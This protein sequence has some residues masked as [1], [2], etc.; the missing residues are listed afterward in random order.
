MFNCNNNDS[1]LQYPYE[2]MSGDYRVQVA[3]EADFP[4]LTAVVATCFKSMPV[5]QLITGPHTQ[6]NLD[7]LAGRYLH[8]HRLHLPAIIKCVHV[9]PETLAEMIVGTAQ[10]YIYPR[11]RT[12]EEMMAPHYLL[13]CEWMRN[14]P[15]KRKATQFFKPFPD[16][17]IRLMGVKAHGL[18]MYMAVLPEWR[19]RGVAT[20]CIQ[21]GIDR[22]EELGVPAYLETSDMG[23]PVYTKLGF[24]TVEEIEYSW[25]DDKGLCP[26]MTREPGQKGKDG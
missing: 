14:G 15:D 16:G 18:L 13:G 11:E 24:K 19:K 20:M 2:K 22:C 1:N 23:V 7:A 4:A 6:S 26:I 10:W 3:D 17:R 8:A 25:E 21:W 9:D 5:E 12:A